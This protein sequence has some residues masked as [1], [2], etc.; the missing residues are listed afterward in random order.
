MISC[1]RRLAFV[2]LALCVTI[3][4]VSCQKA[5]R[6][7]SAGGGAG[8][9]GPLLTAFRQDADLWTGTV[10]TLLPGNDPQPAFCMIVRAPSKTEQWAG[11]ALSESEN[12]GVYRIDLQGSRD[13][14]VYEAKVDPFT[15]SFILAEHSY[16]LDEGR[17]FL[18][19]DTGY[20][21]RVTQ[22]K[23]EIPEV[24]RPGKEEGGRVSRPESEH[25]H[26]ALNELAVENES[27][28]Q[29]LGQR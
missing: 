13:W 21:P 25:F 24:L 8:G 22:V 26:E 23:A 17:L 15:E 11:G 29:F 14:L 18:V 4:L 5:Q 20:P 6:P 1:V 12:R 19:D 9:E 27:V 2:F 10:W 16:D 28:K 3:A 7:F